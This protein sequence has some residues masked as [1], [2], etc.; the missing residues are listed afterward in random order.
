MG[1][2]GDIAETAEGSAT[3]TAATAR[4]YL[5]IEQGRY[6]T[7]EVEAGAVDCLIVFGSWEPRALEVSR[8]ANVKATVGVVVAYSNTGSEGQGS[9]N[10]ASLQDWIADKCERV[11]D[12]VQLNTLDETRSI[13]VIRGL[14]QRI[15]NE[16]GR[17][18]SLVVDFS[19][20]PKLYFLSM[21]AQG[22]SLGQIK[23]VTALYSEPVYVLKDRPSFEVRD[24]RLVVVGRLAHFSATEGVWRPVVVPYLEGAFNPEARRRIVASL[25]F[26]GGASHQ[27]VAQYDPDEL[28]PIL[29]SPGFYPEYTEL[30]G[31]ENSRL[32]KTFQVG[33]ND[34]VK[35]G[36]GDVC[37]V[38]S[39]LVDQEKKRSG[40]RDVVFLCFG[41]KTH[42]LGMTLAGLVLGHPSVVCRIPSR[43]L[44]GKTKPNGFL[45][46]YRITDTSLWTI[47]KT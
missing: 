20:C 23:S 17:P 47:S 14:L 8:I 6:R 13:G 27:V 10:T 12:P 5:A 4:S 15:Y 39:W 22:F 3:D 45:W 28:V 26:E 40:S 1:A 19:C 41:P 38:F 32:L 18:L 36:A 21:I 31:H 35:I 46:V 34:I 29:A 24:G 7:A 37:G 25:G 42:A 44:E 16:I 11:A 2:R 33:S 30:A 43:F 9:A